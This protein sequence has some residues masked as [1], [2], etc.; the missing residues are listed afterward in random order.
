MR[1]ETNGWF[2]RVHAGLETQHATAAHRNLLLT[3]AM[4]LSAKR[5]KA[6]KLPADPE[7]LEDGL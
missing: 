1:E 7:E 3:K 4:D 5:G 6:V 2:S